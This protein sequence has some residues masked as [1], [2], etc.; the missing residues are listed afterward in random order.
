MKIKIQ[1]LA[2]A[3]SVTLQEVSIAFSILFGHGKMRRKMFFS[4]I[5]RR[6][7]YAQNEVH[8]ASLLSFPFPYSVEE[9]VSLLRIFRPHC[10]AAF[11][12]HNLFHY[13][14]QFSLIPGTIYDLISHY[15]HSPEKQKRKP[16]NFITKANRP[17]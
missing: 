5:L 15:F 8:C 9:A 14:A 6:T 11:G 2:L 7:L 4:S 13:F 16:N 17:E 1:S 12:R 3:S 10:F